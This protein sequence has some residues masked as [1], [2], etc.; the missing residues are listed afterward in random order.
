MSNLSNALIRK[1]ASPIDRALDKA[2]S[3]TA[4][5]VLAG[6]LDEAL[7]KATSQTADQVL[8]T[9]DADTVNPPPN[10][11]GA[12]YDEKM[13]KPASNAAAKSKAKAAADSKRKP[14]KA[15]VKKVP[16]LNKKASLTKALIRKA[17]AYKPK[18][19]A[20][21]AGGLPEGKHTGSAT[22][23]LNSG[24]PI[25]DSLFQGKLAG[26][27]TIDDEGGVS[28]RDGQARVAPTALGYGAGAAGGA[29]VGAGI[30]AYM[31]DNKLVGGMT[32][33]AIGAV[34][35]PLALLIAS[36]QGLLDG[37]AGPTT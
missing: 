29:G 9:P 4:D 35:A 26:S 16:N 25:K 3:Q 8:A 7:D 23:P 14:R 34:A 2:T 10:Y 17:A 19:P 28:D 13:K 22:F 32:G 12:K 24:S 21:D 18:L 36:K 5:Q 15:P 1:T 11:Y 27:F 33:G 31:S 30:G 20:I 6:G 37:M